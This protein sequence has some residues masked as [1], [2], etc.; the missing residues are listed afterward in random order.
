[1]NPVPGLFGGTSS[2]AKAGGGAGLGG[3]IFFRAGSL[4]LIK[5]SFSNNSALAGAPTN[6]PATPGSAKG[7]AIFALGTTVF[8][9]DLTFAGNVAAN[10]GTATDDNADIF[11]T[12]P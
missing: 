7:G 11:L 10:A 8:Q 2:G 5:A 6:T 12:A 9:M 4:R 3:A 1:V